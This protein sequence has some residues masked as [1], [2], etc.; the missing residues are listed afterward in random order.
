M[1]LPHILVAHDLSVDD[2]VDLA[3]PPGAERVSLYLPT[4]RS[5]RFGSQDTVALRDLIATAAVE[6]RDREHLAPVRTLVDDT[7]FW[8]H[9]RDGL[10]VFAAPDRTTAVWLSAPVTTC[11]VVS[12]R[13]HVKPL[14]DDVMHVRRFEL[15]ALSHHAVRLI[16]VDGEL[17]HEVDVPD[18]PSGEPDALRWDDREP[19]LQS[20]TGTR[21]GA[22]RVAATFH[23]QGGGADWRDTD[24]ERFLRRVDDAIVRARGT[25]SLPL[26]LAGVDEIVAAYRHLTRCGH[27][28]D[29]HVSGNPDDERPTAL[30]D[31]AR[32][33]VPPA[34][35]E[36][37]RRDR[38]A[39][40]S[41]AAATVDTVEQ[42]V[43]AAVAGQV[44]SVFVPADEHAWGLHRP[45]HSL[46]ELHDE[47]QPGDHDL[48]DVAAVETLRHGGAVH[49][50]PAREMPGDGRVAA[51]LRY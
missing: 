13:F 6:S 45:G 21:V 23:G 38:E 22:G 15:L 14:L 9:P 40:A 30:A 50:V 29:R 19:Q 5:P 12:D 35:L 17:V 11:A 27:V 46:L 51:T 43:I 10:A 36:A 28:V 49:I 33:L 41:G 44:A 18:L 24:D 25:T 16:R 31:R 20:H 8:A 1:A 2:V 48:T 32:E 7:S 39:F 42:A 26:V 3:G 37:E 47:R 34:G 4:H